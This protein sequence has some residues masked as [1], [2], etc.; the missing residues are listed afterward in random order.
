MLGCKARA[1]SVTNPAFS[2]NFERADLGDVWHDTGGRY[3]LADGKLTVAGARNHPLW[4]RKELP[5]NVVIELDAMSK[6]PDGDL[7]VEIFGDGKSFD[8]D[9]GQYDPTG[10]VLIFGGWQNSLSIIGRLGEHEKA[11]KVERSSPRVE[12]NRVYR[13]TIVRRGATIDW[14]I[15]GE[16]FLSWSDPEPLA[17]S[18]HGHFAVNNWAAETFFDNLRIGP[19]N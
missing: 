2:D 14:F 7:K 15:D 1:P 4:L 18:G 9:Q 5:R 8:P 10:Y 12:P 19:T 17:G 3:R 16:A 13:W 6:S 11:V